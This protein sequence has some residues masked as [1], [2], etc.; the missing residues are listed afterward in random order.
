MPKKNP[1]LIKIKY[2]FW[3]FLST[4][5]QNKDKIIHESVESLK[6]SHYEIIK[7][8]DHAAIKD[9]TQKFIKTPKFKTMNKQCDGL[10]IVPVMVMKRVIVYKDDKKVEV[11]TW[12]YDSDGETK[13]L[14]WIRQNISHRL[15]DE[16][17]FYIHTKRKEGTFIEST[18][19]K[20]DM[21]PDPGVL[22]INRAV[23]ALKESESMDEIEDATYLIMGY[24]RDQND[25]ILK[26]IG[27]LLITF[28]WYY[29]P[30]PD[31]LYSFIQGLMT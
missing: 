16:D 25:N 14:D 1:R 11:G 10:I 30:I 13:H 12:F 24:Y 6:E 19:D 3:L 29:G 22:N 23:D 21:R 7:A 15:D 26:V 17:A 28:E 2:P 31:G 4:K 5:T 9:Q 8:T 20:H 27:I 18:G